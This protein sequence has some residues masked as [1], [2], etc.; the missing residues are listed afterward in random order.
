MLHLKR[1]IIPSSEEHFHVVAIAKYTGII[2]HTYIFQYLKNLS[3]NIILS[4]SKLLY[5]C[6]TFLFFLARISLAMK[7]INVEIGLELRL[8]P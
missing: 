1:T 7:L 8:S 3:K 6:S 5:F 4:F 2:S